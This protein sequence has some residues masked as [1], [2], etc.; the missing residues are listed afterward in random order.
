MHQMGAEQRRE[1]RAAVQARFSAR[2]ASGA[3][4]L[5]FTSADVSTGGAFLRSD[6]LLEQGEALALHFEVPGEG[7]LQTQATVAWVRRFPEAGQVAGMGVEFVGLSDDA[8]AALLRWIS[9][10]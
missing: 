5:T 2:D 8:R 9:R 4:T 10:T 7:A 3:G 1:E 6:L